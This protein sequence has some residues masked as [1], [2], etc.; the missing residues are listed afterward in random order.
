MKNLIIFICD[1][2]GL[3]VVILFFTFFP[4]T[5]VAHWREGV[6][7]RAYTVQGQ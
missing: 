7:E 1:R 5:A 4:Y 6:S 2:A 3:L